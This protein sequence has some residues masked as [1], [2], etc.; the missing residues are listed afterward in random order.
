MP[1]ESKVTGR[2]RSE[3]L[4]FF[5][6]TALVMVVVGV[7]AVVVSRTV[8]RNDALSDAEAMTGRMATTVMSPLL[9]RW[10]QGDTAPLNSA[11]AVR[12]GEGYLKEVTVWDSTGKVVYS[13]DPEVIGQVVELPEE[14]AAA[15]ESGTVSSDFET[16]PEVA[17]PKAASPD[18]YVEVYVPLTIPGHPPLALEAYYD[19]GK[20]NDAANNLL[21][22]LLPLV[23]LPLILL[24]LL[25]LPMVYRLVR[26]IRLHEVESRELLERT[27]S[28]SDRERMRFAADLHD[29]PIQDLAGIGYAMGAMSMDVP[30]QHRS[31]MDA[32][33]QALRRSI[34]SLRGLMTDLYPPDLAIGGLENTL[35]ELSRPLLT[36]GIAVDVE[37]EEI[38][39][40]DEERLKA[41]YRVAREVL[42]NAAQH[43]G[44]DRVLVTVD[45]GAQSRPPHQTVRLTITD[46]G[47]G[48]D[49]TQLDRRHE[50][51]LGLRLL[52]DR[53]ANLGGTLDITNPDGGGTCIRATIPVDPAAAAASGGGGGRKLRLGEVKTRRP[54]SSDPAALPERT[55]PG[56]SAGGVTTQPAEPI[57][58][59]AAGAEPTVVKVPESAS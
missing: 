22:Q 9:G 7:G 46:D 31:L 3:L 5:I 35:R 6:A 39:P 36:A 41:I 38:P 42:S 52:R 21:R 11:V 19:Y 28:V 17:D 59:D 53:V 47:V 12:M 30:P 29:G 1:S 14:A 49:E 56:P 54:S 33:Q 26:R 24:Q 32:T 37:V 55:V 45:T 48:M 27:L 40:L 51:H 15:I 20:V 43:S 4:V 16:Q 8:A 57:S 2:A 34:D 23:L 10:L 18:G 44:A 58:G 25:Q 13:D 50:G